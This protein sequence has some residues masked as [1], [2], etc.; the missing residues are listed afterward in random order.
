[1]PELETTD[2]DRAASDALFPVPQGSLVA[3]VPGWPKVWSA[4]ASRIHRW[5]VPPNW[6]PRDWREEIDAESIATACQAIRVF[7]ATRGGSLSRF[8]YYQILAKAMSRYRKEWSFALHFG[9]GRDAVEWLPEARPQAETE[10]RERL[11]RTVTRLPEPDQRLIEF[12]FWE[13][14]SEQEIGGGL[15][16]TK[17]AV[18][19]RKC[20][21]LLEL[22]RAIQKSEESTK[23]SG[24][25]LGG[26]R[27]L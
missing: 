18:N 25:H 14:R 24:C 20:R 7:D 11:F 1:M 2:G 21:I 15:G 6:S 9:A 10:A 16:I 3:T 8:V 26:L 5:R 13:G 23:K 19:K 12:L 22:R 27:N 17:Q 4:T